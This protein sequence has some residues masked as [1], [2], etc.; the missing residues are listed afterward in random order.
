MSE[1]EI[2][3]ISVRFF[4]FCVITRLLTK[5]SVRRSIFILEILTRMLFAYLTVDLMHIS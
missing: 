3:A 2:E 1:E 4:R 5:P